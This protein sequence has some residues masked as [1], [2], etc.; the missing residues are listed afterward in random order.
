L[1]TR[2]GYLLGATLVAAQLATSATAYAQSAAC[3]SRSSGN[4]ARID[5]ASYVQLGGLDQF[6]T[7]RGD[8]RSNPVLLHIHGGPGISFSAFVS[9]FA[10]YEADF[11]VVQWDQRGSGCTFGRHGEATPDVTLDRLASDGIELAERLRGRFGNRKIIVLGH[12]FGSIVA[13]EMVRRAPEQFALYVGTGQISSFAATI[14]AQIAQL[15]ASAANDPD[16]IAQ[17]DALAALEPSLQKFFGVNRL[18][19]SRAPAIDVAFMQELQS[20][21]A[22]VMAP[23]ELADW[24]AGRQAFTPRLLQ[25]TA[26]VDLFATA[27]RL[28][29]PFVV[30]QGSGD[31]NTPVDAVR[32]YFEQVEAPWKDFVV[33][34]GAGHFAHLT[35][36]P[37][38]LSALRTYARRALPR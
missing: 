34:D 3:A 7:M 19:Q 20:R 14:D 32:A 10:P 28:E 17:L 35:H 2:F 8:D 25:Q 27:S 36:T 12:S 22:Q 9:E 31:W 15:R 21:A 5:E 1:N 26:A 29:V 6:V 37:Q 33:V 18:S 11:T 13:V 16:F 30:I 24:Q 38:F 4:G 23:K